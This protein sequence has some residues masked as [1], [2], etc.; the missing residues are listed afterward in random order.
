MD[1]LFP[2]VDYTYKK[3]PT[4]FDKALSKQIDQNGLKPDQEYITEKVRQIDTNLKIRPGLMLIGDSMSGKT[5]CLKILYDVLNTLKIKEIEKY[6]EDY[7]PDQLEKM[8]N[9]N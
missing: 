4:K 8:Q 3:K 1:D 2:G 5:T 6:L 9:E 7:Y